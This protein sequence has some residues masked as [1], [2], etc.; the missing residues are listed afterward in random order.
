MTLADILASKSIEYSIVNN[1]IN[2]ENIGIAAEEK[3]NR[4]V[5]TFQPNN[6]EITKTHSMTLPDA[7][8]AIETRWNRFIKSHPT[9]RKLLFEEW[10]GVYC[11][12]DY[13]S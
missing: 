6:P 1:V 2:V 9:V 3:R 7:V 10:T 8:T 13:F 4:V 11:P 12:L 5:V